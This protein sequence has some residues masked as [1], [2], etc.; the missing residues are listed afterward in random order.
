MSSLGRPLASVRP[1]GC[2]GAPGALIISWGLGGGAGQRRNA[3]GPAQECAGGRCTAV[4]AWGA[5]SKAVAERL[6]RARRRQGP[7]KSGGLHTGRG[8]S[9]AQAAAPS[10]YQCM[11]FGFGACKGGARRR[12]CMPPPLR[13][14]HAPARGACMR[15]CMHGPRSATLTLSLHPTALGSSHQQPGWCAASHRAVRRTAHGAGGGPQP[16]LA[17]RA[18][19]APASLQCQAAP[20]LHQDASRRAAGGWLATA[21]PPWP[22]ARCFCRTGWCR[23]PPLGGQPTASLPAVFGWRPLP[24]CIATG[25]APGSRICGGWCGALRA[26]G[27]TYACC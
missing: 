26:A 21:W 27:C 6:V 7:A 13:C 14:M 9:L 23:E 1:A 15:A 25:R 22:P 12:A 10:L 2:R 18:A 3:P 17:P 4:Q 20:R 19:P 24:R 11:G 5:Q 8:H 16:P